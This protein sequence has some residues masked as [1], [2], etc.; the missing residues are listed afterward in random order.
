MVTVVGRVYIAV[1]TRIC[2]T[3]GCFSGKYQVDVYGGISSTSTPGI[4]LFHTY[5]NTTDWVALSLAIEAGVNDLLV[6][7]NAN[8][9]IG[10]KK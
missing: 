7:G 1:T 9:A 5:L 8:D 2:N 6:V 4:V 3:L 10:V